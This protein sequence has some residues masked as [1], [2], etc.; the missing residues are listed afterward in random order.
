MEEDW[1][2]QRRSHRSMSSRRSSG[3]PWAKR[4]SRSAPPACP[5]ASA[6]SWSTA[7]S[8]ER[9]ACRTPDST[10]TC[11]P[12]SPRPRTRCS[13]PRSESPVLRRL[14]ARPPW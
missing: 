12:R 3:S 14:L 5:R 4:S 1:E 6:T 11:R 10:R 13:R 7:A 9:R 2:E 8:S